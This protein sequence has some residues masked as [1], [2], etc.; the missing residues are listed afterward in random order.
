M[1]TIYAGDSIVQLWV[2]EQGAP[3]PQVADLSPEPSTPFGCLFL[4]QEAE[5]TSSIIPL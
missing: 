2:A 4:E 5:I 1:L 3:P